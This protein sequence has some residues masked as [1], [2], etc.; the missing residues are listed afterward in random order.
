MRSVVW[1]DHNGIPWPQLT[2][3]HCHSTL[4]IGTLVLHGDP[5]QVSLAICLLLGK[6]P[7]KKEVQGSRRALVSDWAGDFSALSFQTPES[8]SGSLYRCEASPVQAISP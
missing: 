7:P 1:C 6:K 4:T 2:K 5:E 8:Q 3:S